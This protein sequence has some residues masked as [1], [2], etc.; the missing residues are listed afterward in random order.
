VHLQTSIEKQRRYAPQCNVEKS[1]CRITAKSVIIFQDEESMSCKKIVATFRKLHKWPGI[2]IAVFAIH[3]AFSGIIMNHRSLFSG[4]EISRKWLPG[5]YE[6]HNWN[7]AAVRGGMSIGEDSLLFFGNIGAWIKTKT[8][9]TDYNQGFPKGIDNRKINQLIR[10]KDRLIAATQFGLFYRSNIEGEWK[11]VPLPN[12]EQ[13]LIDLFVRRDTLMILSRNHLITSPD[14]KKFSVVTLP[15][16]EGYSRSA[17]MFTTLWELHS[18]E[19]FGTLGKL[20]VDLLG[21][22]TLLISVTGL[23]HFFLPKLIRRKKRLTG[24]SGKLPATFRLNLRWHNVV[25]YVFVL[26]LFINTSAGIFLRP[27]LLIPIVN[28]TVGIIPGSHLDNN[29]PWNDKL[30]RGTWNE[31]LR[32]F[33]FSTSEG[34]FAAD[35]NLALPMMRF[36]SQPPVSLMGCNVL[37]PV[38]STKYLIGSFSGM[39][40][41]DAM[42]GNVS[43]FFT[44][45][46]Y[47]APA[48]MARPV[49]DHMTTGYIS[50]NKNRKWIFDYNNGMAAVND[51]LVWEMPAEIRAKSPISLWNLALEIHTGRILEPFI[52]IFYLLYIPLAGI[53]VLLVLF[54]GFFIWLLAHR[55]KGSII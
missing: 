50:D 28:S 15:A 37:E 10:F 40:I 7:Q 30:R 25:G 18:G 32:I 17:G 48:G 51:T 29:N 55:K 36:S 53:C 4:V 24:T 22:V 43:D 5:S 31:R 33:I 49:S 27:P 42:G 8:G 2:I 46:G 54:S 13:R 52:G 34:F 47:E 3:F 39:Y 23:L 19:L 45:I 35:E 6:Y 21:V 44:G 20:L 16:P 11:S 26:F 9:Y 14:L 38:D 12:Q 41:W 1:N